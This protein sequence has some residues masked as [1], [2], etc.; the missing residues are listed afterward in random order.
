MDLINVA[1]VM[2][3]NLFVSLPARQSLDDVVMAA[4][5]SHVVR[6]LIKYHKL[7]WTVSALC[8]HVCVFMIWSGTTLWCSSL[9]HASMECER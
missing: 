9:S 4:K 5:T 2:S 3:P 8:V 6:L 1:M 7:L